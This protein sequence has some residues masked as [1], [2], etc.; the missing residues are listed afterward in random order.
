MGRYTKIV[1]TVGVPGQLVAVLAGAPD[2]P[3]QPDRATDVL[4]IVRVR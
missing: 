2:Q 1:A 3:D 4:R